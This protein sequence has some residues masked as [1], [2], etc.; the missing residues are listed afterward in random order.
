MKTKDTPPKTIGSPDLEKDKRIGEIQSELDKSKES[1]SQNAK[2]IDAMI[3]TLEGLGVPKEKI[4]AL[5][6][7]KTAG[8]EEVKNEATPASK[9]VEELEKNL[10]EKE[11]ELKNVSTANAEDLAERKK[12][13]EKTAQLLGITFEEAEKMANGEPVKAVV[14]KRQNIKKAPAN[15][16]SGI[17]EKEKKGAEDVKIIESETREKVVTPAPEVKEDTIKVTKTDKEKAKNVSKD[18]K[19]DFEKQE[20]EK[21]I[22]FINEKLKHIGLSSAEMA[23]NKAWQN[24]SKAEKLLIIEQASQS[25]LSHVKE[26]GEKRF[27]EQNTIKT[28]WNPKNMRPSIIPKIWHKIG[29]SFF[30]S[31][32][33]KDVLKEVAEGQIKPEE[34]TLNALVQRQADLKLNVIEKDGKAFIEFAKVEKDVS[35]ELKNI[36]D[37]YNQA[38]NDFSKLPDSWKNERSAKSTDK[39]FTTKNHEKYEGIKASFEEAKTSFIEN[40]AKEYIKSGLNKKDAEREAMED[41]RGIDQNIAMLQFTNTNPDAMDELNK[42][43]TES[44]WGRL[45]NNENIWRAGYMAGGATSRAL[46]HATLGLLVAPITS[47]VIGGIR[48]RRKANENVNTAFKEGTTEETRLERKEAGKKGSFDNKNEEIGVFSKVMS[49]TKVNTKEVAA[50]VDAD[51]QK[52]RIDSLVNKINNA[53]TKKEKASLMASL[54]DRIGYIELK[55]QQGLMNYGNKNPIGKNY[56]LYKSLSEAYMVT[57]TIEGMNIRLTKEMK[58]DMIERDRLLQNVMARNEEIFGDKIASYKNKEMLR[59]AAVA[60]GFAVLGQLVMGAY[61]HDGSHVSG[62]TEHTT[63]GHNP[64]GSKHVIEIEKPT[65]IVR[66]VE[67]AMVTA[68]ADHG[69]G[70]IATLRALQHSLKA[71]YGNDLTHAPASVKHILGTDAHKLAQEYGMYKPGQDAESALIKAGSTFKIDGSGNLTYHEGGGHSDLLLEKGGEVKADHLYEGKM[72]D[73]DHSGLKVEHKLPEQVNPETGAPI[74]QHPSS[75]VVDGAH[76]LP[77]QVDAKTGEPINHNLD[78]NNVVPSRGTSVPK[79][80]LIPKREDLVSPEEHLVPKH[81]NAPE[82]IPVVGSTP[83]TIDQVR[84]TMLFYLDKKTEIYGDG[85]FEANLSDRVAHED[86]QQYLKSTTENTNWKNLYSK[87]STIFK[88]EALQEMHDK[89]SHFLNSLKKITGLIPKEKTAF[90]EGESV[91]EYTTR[92]IEQAERMGKLDEISLK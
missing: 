72:S 11:N 51:S 57:T 10:A 36:I 60:G 53:Q 88:T 79:E 87:E 81:A 40:K 12:G 29:K 47:G 23:G 21:E 91:S 31:K 58:E 90:T 28:S 5:R 30:I 92:A 46:T 16:L 68:T 25:T 34:Q 20:K 64:E 76:K 38:A 43:R 1:R 7:D 55:E 45:V 9:R 8:A 24:F 41:A 42:I 37:K 22:I 67:H 13:I 39:L 80:Q 65:P 4:D 78:D 15:R 86:I 56:E 71:E 19:A 82:K 75:E 52:Q 44:S 27:N 26:L 32:A 18:I 61:H 89:M 66:G 85:P 84:E 63:P 6:Q 33:E 74:D 54:Q 14:E 69:H 77:E 49:G 73:T 50:F 59:G 17:T 83:L 3:D 35:P 2:K 62:A 48:A 70:A